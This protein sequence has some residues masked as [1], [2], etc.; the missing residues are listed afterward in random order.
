M[1]TDDSACPTRVAALALEVRRCRSRQW[2]CSVR[3]EEQ[4]DDRAKRKR[5][6]GGLHIGVA[7]TGDKDW[8]A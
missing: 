7:A 1:L 2:R 8:A 5:G 6:E 3:L 4:S